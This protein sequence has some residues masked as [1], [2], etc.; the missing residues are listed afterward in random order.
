MLYIHSIREVHL[1][2]ARITIA[3]VRPQCVTLTF[4]EWNQLA[5]FVL[6]KQASE[7]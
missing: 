4:T 2:S 3:Y 1:T 7:C 6:W 5:V